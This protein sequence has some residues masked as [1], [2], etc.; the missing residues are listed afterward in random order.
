MAEPYCEPSWRRSEIIRKES[1]KEREEGRYDARM[2]QLSPSFRGDRLPNSG[3]SGSECTED[4]VL[5]ATPRLILLL[6]FGLEIGS[7]AGST[8]P[9]HYTAARLMVSRTEA[10][11]GNPELILYSPTLPPTLS[12]PISFL[13]LYYY[14]F[15]KKEEK[16]QT[17]CC[18]MYVWV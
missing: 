10:F 1:A 17:C 4:N 6:R 8:L 13:L 5:T 3:I 12:T 7:R 14:F 16:L 15:F 2:E 18:C 9:I 11:L